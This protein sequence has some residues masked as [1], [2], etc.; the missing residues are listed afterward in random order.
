MICYRKV[1]ILLVSIIML[2]AQAST[3]P[4]KHHI[5]DK[6]KNEFVSESDSLSLVALYNLTNGNSW[7]N[8][9]NWLSGPVHTWHGVDVKD[10]VVDSINLAANW[11]IGPI[12]D[13]FYNLIGL[14]YLFLYQNAITGQISPEIGKLVNLEYF[15][16]GGNDLSG[17]IPPEIG[18]LASMK[19]LYLD[20]NELE[21]PIPPEIGNLS[22]VRYLF[23]N[24]NQLSGS[25]PTE[26]GNL[27]NLQWLRLSN[28]PLSGSIPASISKLTNLRKIQIWETD[29]SGSIPPEFGDLTS[30]VECSLGYNQLSGPI[31]PE[32]CN[33]LSLEYLSLCDNNL[34]GQIPLEIGNLVELEQLYLDGNQ[35]SGCIPEEIGNLDSLRVIAL[36][37]NQLSG[38]LPSSLGNLESLGSLYLWDN[39]FEGSIP[40]EF[41][42]LDNLKYLSL[43]SNS[44][45]GICDLS[46]NVNLKYVELYNNEFTFKDFYDS[47]LDF[48]SLSTC[49]YAPQKLIGLNSRLFYVHENNDHTINF[50]DIAYASLSDT[51][52]EYLV[53]KEN[54]TILQWS[55]TSEYIID[56]FNYTD[57][58]KYHFQIR[59]LS[60]PDLIL[61][62]E[63]FYVRLSSSNRTPTNIVV[64]ND[65]ILE[66]MPPGS[67][68]GLLSTAD[69]DQYDE[70]IYSLAIGDGIN[71]SGNNY[72]QIIGD[73]LKTLI[74]FDYEST[75]S[76]N[77]YVQSE[78][79]AGDI[80][81][82]EIVIKVG[83]DFET[84][85][86][87]VNELSIKVYPNPSN[88]IFHAITNNE[89][90]NIKIFDLKGNL[91]YSRNGS[92]IITIDLTALNSGM[93]IIRILKKN[94]E[95]YTSR[96]IIH[97]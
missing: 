12:P 83:N 92:N 28:N 94:E 45:S 53:V 48:L 20:Y 73:S 97:K 14:R 26:I 38:T 74:E 24:Y 67:L 79:L 43:Y 39:N 71:D 63:D 1:S 96:I 21:G 29:I 90:H 5:Q 52:N 10:G 33:M 8:N 23:L 91:L 3:L 57:T 82:K 41:R 81:Q 47:R 40:S 89:I 78:D 77:I 31:P 65:T 30:L 56:Q 19:Y 44:F 37:I 66:G 70:H 62:S 93:Y 16:I 27:S 51:V 80:F 59:N 50:Q 88:G 42:N 86:T 58:G 17:S 22:N 64:S 25:I 18:D 15:W 32:I 49:E 54:D 4:Y 60:F 2:I 84:D 13:E 6:G 68:V 61:R 95:K 46:S 69:S 55:E 34:T 36:C 9:S 35:L 11:L 76:Y 87:P 72:F 7:N 75:S 85:A